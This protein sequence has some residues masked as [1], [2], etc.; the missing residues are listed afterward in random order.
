MVRLEHLQQQC[1]QPSRPSSR[2]IVIRIASSHLVLLIACIRS[3]FEDFKVNLFMI[4]GRQDF[5]SRFRFDCSQNGTVY[6]GL[7]G[8]ESHIV[9]KGI[10]GT[11]KTRWG[12]ISPKE[13]Y[14]TPDPRPQPIYFAV[15]VLLDDREGFDI[16]P[17]PLRRVFF[18]VNCWDQLNHLC[19]HHAQSFPLQCLA[20]VTIYFL[21]LRQ[22]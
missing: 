10:S 7:I 2:S 16:S 19:N 17:P 22:A 11:D 14:K 5:Q 21:L 3:W 12:F 18:S 4:A 15:T 20:P 13:R 6:S 9:P 8:L 1:V